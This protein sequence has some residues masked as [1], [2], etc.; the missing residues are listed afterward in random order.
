MVIEGKLVPT[1]LGGDGEL[2]FTEQDVID[3]AKVVA[4]DIAVPAVPY[5]L[6]EVEEAAGFSTL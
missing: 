6:E 3:A 5:T 4:G 1:E 2:T